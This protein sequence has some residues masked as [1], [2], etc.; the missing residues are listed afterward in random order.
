VFALP[1]LLRA[2]RDWPMRR[3]A[4]TAAVSSNRFVWDNIERHLHII[5]LHHEMCNASLA[6][7]RRLNSYGWHSSTGELSPTGSS[8]KALRRT[9]VAQATLNTVSESRALARRS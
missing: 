2:L 6:G 9:F 7:Q 4:E 8:K 3:A 1:S 5:S